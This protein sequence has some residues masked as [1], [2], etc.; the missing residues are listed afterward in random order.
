MADDDATP[1]PA[2]PGTHRGPQARYRLVRRRL[3]RPRW[4]DSNRAHLSDTVAGGGQVALV[5]VHHGRAS[6]NSGMPTPWIKPKS[7]LFMS[8]SRKPSP[9]RLRDK[10]DLS[11]FVE[12]SDRNVSIDNIARIAKGLQIEPWRLLKDD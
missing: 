4:R 12:R 10:S 11:Q 9:P 6:S 3:G 2:R 1:H 7:K 5:L 8:A